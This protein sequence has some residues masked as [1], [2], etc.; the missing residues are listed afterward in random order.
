MGRPHSASANGPANCLKRP[1]IPLPTIGGVQ[2]LSHADCLLFGDTIRQVEPITCVPEILQ[3]IEGLVENKM[4]T[5]PSFQ[6][7]VSRIEQGDAQDAAES[8]VERFAARLAA[9]AAQKMN[10]RLQKRVGPED[11]VQ[12]VFAT[13]FRRVDNGQLE[14]RDWDSLWGLLARITVWRICRYAEHH[15]A[16]QRSLK[17]EVPLEEDLRALDRE[18]RAEDVLMAEE[19]HEQLTNGLSERYRPIAMQ[20]LDGV[21]HETIAAKLNTS[22]STVERVHRRARECL[23]RLLEEVE[24]S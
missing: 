1:T 6:R 3:F 2:S 7:L 13:F 4:S 11:V 18:P 21:T 19:L 24:I 16:A 14:L 10:Q 12:S 23:T 22:I 5:S 17:R 8:I 9:L 15:G 20:I